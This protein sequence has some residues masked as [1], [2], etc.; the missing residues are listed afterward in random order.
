MPFCDI[1]L[2]ARIERA[3]CQLIS[4]A[5]RSVAARVG[6]VLA[7]PISGGFAAFTEAGSPLNKVAGLG[8]E[9]ELDEAALA[10]VEA[11]CAA[12]GAGVLAEVATL[13]DPRVARALTRRGYE[14]VGVENVLGRKLPLANA[15]VDRRELRL[16]R[17]DPGELDLWL[18]VVVSGFAAPDAQ[19]VAAHEQHDR[20]VLERVIRDFASAN[21]VERYLARLD[22]RAVGGGSMRLFEGIA[23]LCGAATLPDARRRGVQSALLARRLADAGRSG[24]TLAVMTTQPGSKSQ[25]NA[26]RQGFELLYSRNVLAREAR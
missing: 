25:Q 24:C 20:A 9:G 23:Q 12:H 2:A 5:C 4:D 1:E 6:P 10:E 8:F 3:E 11:H 17:S 13:A 14:L 26:Q 21:G 22:G 7:R 19:G 16:E 18:D 15:A